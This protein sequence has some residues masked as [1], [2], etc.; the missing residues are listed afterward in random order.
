LTALNG[1]V[2]PSME[3]L[4]SAFDPSSEVDGVSVSCV[5]SERLWTRM[6]VVYER[7]MGP[8]TGL[9]QMAEEEDP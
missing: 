7:G 3:S 9:E 2:A 5:F 6:F 1:D 4:Q 8:A